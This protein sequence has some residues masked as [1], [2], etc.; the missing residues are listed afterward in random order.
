[1]MPMRIV[2]PVLL[3]NGEAYYHIDGVV[4]NWR[5]VGRCIVIY[6]STVH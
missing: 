6:V 5:W 3:C 2:L 4:W 1:M